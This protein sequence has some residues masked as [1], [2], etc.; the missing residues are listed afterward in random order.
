MIR[1][2]IASALATIATVL[3]VSSGIVATYAPHHGVVLSLVAL[4]FGGA[5]MLFLDED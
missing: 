3:L 2:T 1:E 5:A 4:C